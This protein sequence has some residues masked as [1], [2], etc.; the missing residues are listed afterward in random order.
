MGTPRTRASV[1]RAG[2][3]FAALIAALIDVQLGFSADASEAQTQS[4]IVVVGAGGS[5]EFF[6]VFK[7]TAQ[8]WEAVAAKG[9]ATVETIGLDDGELSDLERLA[10][11][12]KDQEEDGDTLWIVLIGHGT[13]DGKSAKFNL[14][15]PDLAA[16]T[17]ATYLERFKRPLVVI[18]CAS[19]SAPFINRLSGAGRI[20]VTSTDSGYEM[21]YARFGI[22]LAE[23]M[24]ANEVDLDKDDQTSILEA[25]L[26][27]STQTVAFYED[28]GRLV[29]EHALIDDN[30]DARG[31]PRTFFRGVRV[32]RR[33]VGMFGG[34]T[35]E[36]E[37]DG[38]RAN[39]IQLIRSPSELALTNEQRQKRD[40]L[41]KQIEALRTKKGEI[42]EDDYY[43]ELERLFLEVANVVVP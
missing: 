41:E 6:T 16:A 5:D 10:A 30:G 24:L 29:T 14:R 4:V 1:A 12:L 43:A 33:G 3:V 13:F 17:M 32:E 39:Q 34:A 26:A 7:E 31:T 28:D 9:K 11:V 40:Q 27:A 20:V 15:G 42:P 18:N 19:S 25:F 37:A 8:K 2:L 35:K 38:L 23:T 22:H 36:S 21:N